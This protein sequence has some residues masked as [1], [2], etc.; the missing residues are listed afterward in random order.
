MNLAYLAISDICNY[1]CE[2]CPCKRK[3]KNVIEFEEFKEYIE[4]IKK[5][6]DVE[7][8]VL[9]GGEP[10]I[11][12]QFFEILK[13]LNSKGM[14]ITLLSNGS[15]LSNL[16]FIENIKK[17]F[18]I[19]RLNIVMTLYNVSEKKHD[20]GTGV[21]GSFRNTLLAFDLLI[22]NNIE[23]K[24][25]YCISKE[26]YKSIS[27]FLKY[28]DKRFPENVSFQ[29]TSLDFSGMSIEQK[30]KNYYKYKNVKYHLNKALRSFNDKRELII[31][32]TP[33]C[34]SNYK[35]WKY[36]V[37]KQKKAY[38]SYKSTTTESKKVKYDCDC[39]SKKCKKCKVYDIC[40][41][42]YKTNYEYIGDKLVKAIKR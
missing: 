37:K 5:E 30:K 13:Y 16:E 18:D 7:R 29:I 10:T 32:N 36:Y 22:E 9:S 41:G 8:I 27:K 23:V 11:H 6:K 17:S 19:N 33:L 20:I 3:R 14:H 24:L 25:K 39:F 2:N 26:N 38:D 40:P 28:F 15:M 21:K 1:K 34:A 12:P 35:Y 31:V 4:K 42:I